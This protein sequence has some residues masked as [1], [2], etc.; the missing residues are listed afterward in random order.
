MRPSA[1]GL[2]MERIRCLVVEDSEPDFILLSR[3][4]RA[5]GMEPECLRVARR[6]DLERALSQNRWDVVLSDYTVPGMTFQEGLEL[7]RSSLPDVPVILVS[8]SIG[9]EQAVDSLKMGVSDFV[10]KDH[11]TKL[12]PSI[13]RSLRE[14]VRRPGDERVERVLRI[15]VGGALGGGEPDAG[16][17]TG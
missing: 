8:G 2:T 9:E 10:L 12:A 14:A 6:D 11:L 17:E 7:V 5:E 3:R 16:G 13:R 1:S 4:L 15:D